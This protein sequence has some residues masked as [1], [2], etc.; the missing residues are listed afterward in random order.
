MIVVSFIYQIDPAELPPVP[1]E[2]S[3]IN[4]NAAGADPRPN[5]VLRQARYL[6]ARVAAA[7]LDSTELARA[8]LD[9]GAAGIEAGL[10]STEIQ[11]AFEIGL[12]DGSGPTY[13]Y[14]GPEIAPARCT[15][16]TE[17][18]EACGTLLVPDPA[19]ARCVYHGRATR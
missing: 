15:Q 7:D 17:T 14:H 1:A 18:G 10:R 13:D 16:P 5:V 8:C 19:G 9:V 12:R 4:S 11:R 2:L 6:G 3:W